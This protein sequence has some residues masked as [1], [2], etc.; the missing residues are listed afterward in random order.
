M[1]TQFTILGIIFFFIEIV[2]LKNTT[3]FK[4]IKSDY[5]RW[6]GFKYEERTEEKPIKV[7][8]WWILV[9]IIGNCPILCIFT[10]V[11]FWSIWIAKAAEESPRNE[12]HT[13]WRLHSKPVKKIIKFLNKEV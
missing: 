5:I 4:Y 8:L 7:K 6:K 11:T 9:L 3:Y 10:F 13:Y 12:Y 2:I 1:L